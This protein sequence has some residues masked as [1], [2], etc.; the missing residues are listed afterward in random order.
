MSR[1]NPTDNSPN[2]C[3]RWFEWNGEK[4][5]LRYYDKEKK[6]RVEVD[7]PFTF[8]LLDRLSTITGW[9]NNSESGIYANEVRDTRNERLLVKAFK[10]KDPIAE[11]FYGT[12]KDKIKANQGK[13]TVNLYIAYKDEAGDLALGSFRVHGAAMSAWLDF[14]NDKSI[15]PDIY[16]KATAIRAT[17]HGEK[18]GGK[19]KIEWEAPI[20]ELVAISAEADQQALVL[21]HTLQEYLK[22]YFSRTKVEQAE[23]PPE[24]EQPPTGRSAAPP[25]GDDEIPF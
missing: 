3:K 13:F 5:N 15:R 2:P 8:L 22:A 4:G 11:G 18:G 23:A 7:L 20:F 12:I 17:K 19:N 16:K 9:H 21:D 24:Q 25:D 10:L 6:E 1:S 14:E